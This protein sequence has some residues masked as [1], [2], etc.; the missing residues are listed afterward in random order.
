MNMDINQRARDITQKTI[1]ITIATAC[2]DG[3][4]WNTPVYAAFDDQYNFFWI[5]T[6]A[7][8]HSKNIERD[9]RIFVVVFD[10]SQAEGTGEGVY[11][12]GKAFVLEDPEEIVHAIPFYYDRVN[13]PHQDPK[14]FLGES[15]RRLYAFVPEQCWMNTDVKVGAFHVDGRKAIRLK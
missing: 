12:Q 1:Y 9:S 15:P 2:E 13:K 8:Q 10:S 6:P 5:S 14:E 3:S 11:M 7:A 4:P